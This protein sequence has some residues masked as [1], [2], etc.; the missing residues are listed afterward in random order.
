M[1]FGSLDIYVLPFKSADFILSNPWYKIPT[2]ALNQKNIQLLLIKKINQLTYCSYVAENQTADKT[3]FGAFYILSSQQQNKWDF[4]ISK[5]NIGNPKRSAAKNLSVFSVHILYLLHLRFRKG[6]FTKQGKKIAQLVCALWF[7]R[8]LN[9]FLR[10]F[11]RT[12]TI[13]VLRVQ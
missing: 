9:L 10:V 6:L 3:H 8:C 11:L 1:S 13:H 2:Q 7:K 12:K 4:W 5:I